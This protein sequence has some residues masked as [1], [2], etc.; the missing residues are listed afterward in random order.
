[1]ASIALHISQNGIETISFLDNDPIKREQTIKLYNFIKSDLEKL[2]KK[3][4][5]YCP[6]NIL[7]ES[8]N[9]K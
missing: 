6:S 3:V 7:E 8:E 5:Q 4:L 2:E 1:M 9:E